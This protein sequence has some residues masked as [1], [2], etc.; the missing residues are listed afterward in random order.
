MP[1]FTDTKIVLGE[2]GA[3]DAL[4]AHSLTEFAD[5]D[6]TLIGNSAFQYQD[7][8]ETIYLPKV[9]S[10]A[11]NAFLNCSAMKNFY[12]GGSNA[13]VAELNSSSAFSNTGHSLIRVRDDLVTNYCNA[14]NWSSLAGRIYG[15]NDITAPE[16][17]ETEIS[18]DM[19]TFKGYVN[20]GTAADRYNIGNYIALDLGTEGSGYVQIVAKNVRE[21]ANSTDKAQLEFVTMFALNTKHRVNPAY[22]AGIEGT[23][24][25]GGYDKSEL[26]TYIEETIWPLFPQDWKDIIKECKITSCGYDTSGKR[27]SDMESTAKISPLSYREVFAST[28]NETTGPTYDFAF[29]GTNARV[30]RNNSVPMNWWLRTAGG[31]SY[32]KVVNSGGGD[33]TQVQTNLNS[34]VL[35]FSV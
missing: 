17:D 26:K 31:T 35:R 22:S 12:I 29:A 20:A 2:A 32:Q 15:E 10:I 19:A 9:S 16:W 5:S 13:T 14:T 7:S 23:G 24:A 6:I 21:L 18:D 3:L 1:T 25:I 8:L 30:I 4:V 11:A 34:L 28:I 33:S 27:V